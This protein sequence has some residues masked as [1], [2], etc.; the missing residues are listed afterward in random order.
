MARGIGLLVGLG[1][2]LAGGYALAN[3]RKKRI[4]AQQG[5]VV[6]IFVEFQKP[7][8]PAA[9]KQDPWGELVTDLSLRFQVSV[10]DLSTV[11]DSRGV[12]TYQTFLVGARVKSAT[13]FDEAAWETWV[14]PSGSRRARVTKVFVGKTADQIRTEHAAELEAIKVKTL[15]QF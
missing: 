4:A 3:D 13:Y 15:A 2:L 14:L 7:Y 11:A 12:P 5:D 8:V 10:E 1:V 6:A 9:E